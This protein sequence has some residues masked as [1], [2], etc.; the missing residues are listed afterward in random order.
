MKGDIVSEK[1]IKY[2]EGKLRWDLLPLNEVEDIVKVLTH[3]AKK[4]AP[5]NWRKVEDPRSRY[6][7]AAMRHLASWRRGE[8]VDPESGIPHLA[9]A[10][11]NLLFLSFFDNEDGIKTRTWKDKI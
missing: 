9:H 10:G 8:L 5:N 1:G 4:Y 7:A 2:D 6:Y 3:G 11:C